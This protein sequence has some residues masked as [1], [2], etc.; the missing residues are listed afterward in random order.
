MG[1][2]DL[3]R[4]LR[5]TCSTPS[6]CNFARTPA[7]G[8]FDTSVHGTQVKSMAF[9]APVNRLGY[10]M[11][12][13]VML[14]YVI[15]CYAML[16]YASMSRNRSRTVAEIEEVFADICF[17]LYP[18]VT[19]VTTVAGL[20]NTYRASSNSLQIWREADSLNKRE[21]VVRMRPSHHTI[22][23]L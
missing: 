23:P 8:R 21:L 22:T 20:P 14:C 7:A 5:T 12:C 1:R 15:L 11:L 6:C 9:T 18:I 13:Y 17:K 16:W 2:P 19:L 4:C 10:A 3:S